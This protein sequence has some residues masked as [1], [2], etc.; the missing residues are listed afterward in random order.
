MITV[1]DLMMSKTHPRKSRVIGRWIPDAGGLWID[2]RHA[3]WRDPA[4]ASMLSH[5]A[6]HHHPRDAGMNEQEWTSL[7]VEM[8]QKGLDRQGPLFHDKVRQVASTVMG[9]LIEPTSKNQA[10]NF[11][12][13]LLQAPPMLEPFNVAWLE[14]IRAGITDVLD[15][16]GTELNDTNCYAGQAAGWAWHGFLHAMSRYPDPDQTRQQMLTLEKVARVCSNLA[17]RGLLRQWVARWN[18]DHGVSASYQGPDG[19]WQAV[20]ISSLVV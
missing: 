1:Y 2:P 15:Y 13:R 11:K 16:D 14:A 6:F 8:W 17:I 5:D 19:M 10:S 7:G 18:Q 12:A 3:I 4:T 9:V 20:T